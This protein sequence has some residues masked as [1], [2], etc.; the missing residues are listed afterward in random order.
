MNC[1]KDKPFWDR[2]EKPG[3][4]RVKRHKWSGKVKRHRAAVRRFWK[5]NPEYYALRERIF[6]RDGYCCRYCGKGRPMVRLEMDHVIPKWRGGKND[7]GNL[8][9]ACFECNQKKGVKLGW[10]PKPIQEQNS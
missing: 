9:T 6:K 7:A 5:R 3:G 8:V 10:T 2:N 4:A 1:F